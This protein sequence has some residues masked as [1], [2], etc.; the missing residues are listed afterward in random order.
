MPEPATIPG[1]PYQPHIDVEAGPQ[2]NGHPSGGHTGPPYGKEA[3]SVIRPDLQRRPNPTPVLRDEYRYC[4]REGFVKPKR[5][6]KQLQALYIGL[7]LFY[8]YTSLSGVWEGTS[9]WPRVI[10]S[11]LTFGCSVVC[12]LLIRTTT[13]SHPLQCLPTTITAH[14]SASVSVPAICGISSCSSSGP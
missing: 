14:G 12:L 13:K 3:A 2:A 4:Y 7:R 8:R 1:Y 10:T 11:V 5:K 6:F 9:S